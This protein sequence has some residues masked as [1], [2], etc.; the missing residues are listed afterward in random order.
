MR[1]V[2]PLFDKNLSKPFVREGILP[3][4]NPKPIEDVKG[5]LKTL[6]YRRLYRI[7]FILMKNI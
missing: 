6:P 3:S 7:L 4:L 1:K 5:G 2:Q